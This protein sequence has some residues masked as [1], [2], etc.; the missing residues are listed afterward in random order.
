[1]RKRLG[2]LLLAAL[3]L[4]GCTSFHGVKPLYPEVGNP[5][6]P[7]ETESLRPTFRWEASAY[8]DATY[9]FIV[10]EGVRIE[11][12]MEGVKRSVG[13]EIYYRQGLT[14]T[15]HTIE[16][17]LKPDSDYYWS[18]RVRRGETV[19]EWALYD[20]TLFLGTAYVHAGNQPFIFKTPED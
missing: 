1:M 10:Y 3:L 20:Y 5:R 6:F 8:P 15:E 17:T 19:S 9:D 13:K 7:T 14:G 2:L 16:E 18:V 12:F 11:S 4:A